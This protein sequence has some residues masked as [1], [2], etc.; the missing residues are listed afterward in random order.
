[1]RR[2]ICVLL[3]LLVVLFTGCSRVM[4]GTEASGTVV[5]DYEGVSFSEE[6]TEDELETVIKILNGKERKS[7]VM[8]GIPSCGFSPEIAFVINGTT[9]MMARDTCETLM[10]YG[11]LDYIDVSV[12][13]Q[14]LLEAIFTS[15]GGSLPCT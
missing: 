6:L 15:H 2:L 10:I 8:H 9:Y 4:I 11:G 12:K 13:E 1:M 5:Y 7:T 14:D 3:V